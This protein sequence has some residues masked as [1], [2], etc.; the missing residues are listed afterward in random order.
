[1][2]ESR[3]EI[4]KTLLDLAQKYEREGKQWVKLSVLQAIKHLSG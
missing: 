1:M 4:V 2:D 3:K